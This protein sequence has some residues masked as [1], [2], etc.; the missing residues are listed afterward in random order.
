MPSYSG[1]IMIRNADVQ[2]WGR[3][4]RLPARLRAYSLISQP[5]RNTGFTHLFASRLLESSP[6]TL[7]H[8]SFP[9]KCTA[10]AP[11]TSHSV[12]FPAMLKLEHAGAPP[13][14][15]RTQSRQCD[16]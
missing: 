5:L 2:W 3:R 13:L 8:I 14:H 9:S 11:S 10:A 12:Y 1:T 7:S 4:F 15:A 16:E 6:L